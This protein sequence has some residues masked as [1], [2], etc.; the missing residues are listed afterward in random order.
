[1]AIQVDNIVVN[2]IQKFSS[3]RNGECQEISGIFTR[4]VL[5]NNCYSLIYIFIYYVYWSFRRATVEAA[6]RKKKESERRALDVVEHI[7]ENSAVEIQWLADNV[8]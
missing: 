7:V 1:M 2:L 8:S 6:F 5:T 4:E 3:A